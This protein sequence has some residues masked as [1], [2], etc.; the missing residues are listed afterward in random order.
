MAL[1][2]DEAYDID[3]AAEVNIKYVDYLKDGVKRAP[4]LIE[5]SAP[6]KPNPDQSSI[7]PAGGD[8]APRRTNITKADLRR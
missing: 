4:S 5:A 1:P 8:P 7:A 2:D 3:M 6:F